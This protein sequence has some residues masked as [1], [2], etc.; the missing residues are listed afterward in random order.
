ML[1]FFQAPPKILVD[2]YLDAIAKTY[3]VPFEPEPDA[4]EAGEDFEIGGGGLI[5]F[6][7]PAPP[8]QPTE[9]KKEPFVYPPTAANVSVHLCINSI[10][11][12]FTY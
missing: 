3:N 4:E 6:S 2:K 9:Q 1:T 10:N 11:L 5:D 12:L 8:L 7:E